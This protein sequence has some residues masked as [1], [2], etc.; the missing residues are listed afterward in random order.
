MNSSWMSRRRAVRPL[1]RYSLWPERYRRRPITTS[2]GLRLQGCFLG[3]ALLA[4]RLTIF[5]RR[6]FNFCLGRNSR[7]GRNMQDIFGA[8]TFVA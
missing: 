2:P 7:L 5:D 1:I 8:F 4:K 3:S 6:G